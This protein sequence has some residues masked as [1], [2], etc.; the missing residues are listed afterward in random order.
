VTLKSG[1]HGYAQVGNES[2]AGGDGAE[3]AFGVCAS[4]ALAAGADN[5]SVPKMTLINIFT[6]QSVANVSAHWRGRAKRYHAAC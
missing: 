5:A 3:P 6:V 1:T 2:E 4:T